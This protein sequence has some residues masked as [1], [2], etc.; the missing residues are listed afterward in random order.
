MLKAET[1]KILEQD[2]KNGDGMIRY[3]D[4]FREK[5]NFERRGGQE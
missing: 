1:D 4:R 2:Y 5:K 3:W